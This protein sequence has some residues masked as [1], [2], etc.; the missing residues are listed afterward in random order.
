MKAVTDQALRASAAAKKYTADVKAYTEEVKSYT[1]EVAKQTAKKP[2]WTVT[3]PRTGKVSTFADRGEAK[4]FSTNLAKSIVRDETQRRQELASLTAASRTQHVSQVALAKMVSNGL[5]EETKTD[6]KTT[7]K[8]TGSLNEMSIADMKLASTAGF[9]IPADVKIKSRRDK[10]IFDAITDAIGNIGSVYESVFKK[11]TDPINKAAEKS[12]K[13]SIESAMEGKPVEGFAA[14]AVGTALRAAGGAIDI[15]TFPVRPA[16]WNEVGEALG[17]LLMPEENESA[18]DYRSRLVAITRGK[19]SG[20]FD[21]A[22]RAKIENDLLNRLPEIKL[23]SGDAQAGREFREA[24]VSSIMADPV[25]FL[26]EIG[27]GLVGAKLL[28]ASVGKL[29]KYKST[30]MSFSD[31]LKSLNEHPW[32]RGTVPAMEGVFD[33]ELL[34]QLADDIV[35]NPDKTVSRQWKQLNY[36][37]RFDKSMASV[38]RRML[39]EGLSVGTVEVNPWSMALSTPG[40]LNIIRQRLRENGLTDAEID[41]VLVE[42]TQLDEINLSGVG[43]TVIYQSSQSIAEVAGTKPSPVSATDISVRTGVRTDVIPL[44]I[45]V[46]DITLEQGV[47]QEITPTQPEPTEPDKP[48]PKP[49]KEAKPSKP[50]PS[51]PEPSKPKIP[52]VITKKKEDSGMS[53]NV[54]R[55]LMGGTEE[56][57]RVIFDY[58]KGPSE[59][60]TVKARS[61]PQALS[62]AQQKRRVKYVPS[63]VDIAKRS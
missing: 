32:S 52:P 15:V 24:V 3:D 10:T 63:E 27:G 39:A 21:E 20:E 13:R 17:L 33:P 22:Q 36:T 38:E 61:F 6:G 5:A 29:A 12:S 2:T 1:E 25:G 55:A 50:E 31:Y 47:I 28:S 41:R 9:N 40:A 54:F 43:P 51:K 42:V 45:Q 48:K 53:P 4:T 60:F 56:G 62:Q 11:V 34:Y 49:P 46:P 26:A 57:Y 8:F 14:Y 35:L 19:K 23:S 30:R 18:S 16:E 58:P 37:K 44:T 7:Y 59:T